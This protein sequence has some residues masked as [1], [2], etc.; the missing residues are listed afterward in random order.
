VLLRQLSAH[1]KRFHPL[2][3]K[4]FAAPTLAPLGGDDADGH[5]HEHANH[6]GADERHR[7]AARIGAG[8][9][10][11]RDWSKQKIGTHGTPLRVGG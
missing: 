5:H 11:L 8:G 6:A 2:F 1:L 9:H 7:D 4:Q 3:V 10:G